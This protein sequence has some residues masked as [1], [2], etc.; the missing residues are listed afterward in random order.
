MRDRLND[1]LNGYMVADFDTACHMWC[2]HCLD[3]AF[4]L[5]RGIPRLAC[6]TDCQAAAAISL[7]AWFEELVL[8]VKGPHTTQERDKSQQAAA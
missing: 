7:Q 1:R 3:A 6:V 5:L 4:I 8:C 2:P